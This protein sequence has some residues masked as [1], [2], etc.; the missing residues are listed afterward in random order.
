VASEEN[1]VKLWN[2]AKGKQEAIA[3][4][5][6]TDRVLSI[7]FSP[8]GKTLA[9]GSEDETVKLWNIFTGQE[10]L[11]L[12]ANIGSVRSVG[13]A[14]DGKTLVTGHWR[15]D[16]REIK[17]WH[18]AR[19]EEILIQSMSPTARTLFEEAKGLARKENLEGVIGKLQELKALDSNLNFEPKAEALRLTIQDLLEV[20]R[21]LAG[22]QKFEDAVV[23]FE[24]VREL[25]PQ[26]N[27]EPQAEVQRS[28]M[29]ACQPLITE[30]EKHIMQGWDY[31]RQN[32]DQRALAEFQRGIELLVKPFD[33][34]YPP[35][36]MLIETY[37]ECGV[38][39]FAQGEYEQA[40]NYW[41]KAT[42]VKP[43]DPRAYSNIGFA[44]YELNQLD[45]AITQWKF[46]V[47]SNSQFDEVWAGLGIALYD[48][49]QTEEAIAAYQKALEID[50]N[51]VSVEWL[52]DSRSWSEK[53]LRSVTKLLQVIAKPSMY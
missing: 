35:S 37:L 12:Q 50:S 15:D 11:T 49:G 26:L 28:F 48:K 10:L 21:K 5:G 6:H 20:G 7:A 32:D 44:Y 19:D 53:S 16:R 34:G 46:A 47:N 27:I 8:D 25:N 38:I 17:L 39:S 52:R 18:S 22:E 33:K 14:P 4:K 51:F 36:P 29:M 9:T 42:E 43:D 40:V 13:F 31:R 30:G 1:Y 3:F 24:R 45:E 2:V 41:K 23:K